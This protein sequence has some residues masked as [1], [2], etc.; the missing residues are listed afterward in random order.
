MGAGVG[1]SM[2]V[3][4]VACL[5]LH[6]TSQ[7]LI[8]VAV[9]FCCIAGDGRGPYS[10]HST[11]QLLIGLGWTVSATVDIFV[12][13]LRVVTRC[14]WLRS[15]IE[16]AS[17]RN[18][19]GYLFFFRQVFVGTTPTP[20]PPPPTPPHIHTHSPTPIN[21]RD[22]EWRIKHATSATPIPTPT[23][24]PTPKPTHCIQQL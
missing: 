5:I 18:T 16:K 24:A 21:N 10:S 2:G 4:V 20:T 12:L 15:K 22:V 13:D 3:A 9:R 23:P 19:I 14:A 17:Y 1:V 11:S 8:G 6:S 7:L